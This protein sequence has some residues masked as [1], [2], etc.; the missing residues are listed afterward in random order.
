MNIWSHLKSEQNQVL[1]CGIIIILGEGRDE[2]DFCWLRLKT[3][4]TL[5]TFT[6]AAEDATNADGNSDGE[7][8]ESGV[9]LK[10]KWLQQRDKD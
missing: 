9:S 6:K 4:L 7:A 10:L 8:A 1:S 2:G 5:T 3:I